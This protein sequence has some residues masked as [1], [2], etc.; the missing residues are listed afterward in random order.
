MNRPARGRAGNSVATAIAAAIA[1]VTTFMAACGQTGRAGSADLILSGGPVI[2]LDPESRV[3]EAVAPELRDMT[4]EMTVFNGEVVYRRETGDNGAPAVDA[5]PSAQRQPVLLLW[6][7]AGPDAVALD[8]AVVLDAPSSLPE[9]PGPYRVEGRGPDGERHFSLS[10]VPAIEAETGQGSF[11][12]MLPVDPVWAGS[13]ARITLSGPA[14]SHSLDAATDL[15]IA[16]I[17]DRETGRIRAILRGADALEGSESRLR[18]AVDADVSF[19]RG[20]PDAAAL[21]GS[22]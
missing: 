12:F 9:S 20:L 7:R 6:G 5:L 13:L 3:A 10:F 15:P 8:P 22:R 19:S 11:V 1:G 17:T 14:G 4:C 18:L 16:V 21:R 2:T